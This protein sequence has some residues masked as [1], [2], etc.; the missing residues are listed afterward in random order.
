MFN[1]IKARN[2]SPSGLV[3]NLEVKP[4]EPIN[5]VYAEELKAFQG[6]REQQN[7]VKAPSQEPMMAGLFVVQTANQWMT[8]ASKL[9][10]PK[11]LFDEFWHEGEL[12]ISYSDSN[13]GKSCL[14]VQIAN[15]IT[16]GIP[17]AG[18]R[19]EADRQPV[20]LIDCELTEVQFRNRY[21]INYEGDY[22]FDDGFMQ[23]R[24]NSAAVAPEKSGQF[25]DQLIRS[26]EEL[27]KQ[28]GCKVV[29]VDNI[30]YLRGDN[31]RARD[32]LPLMRRLK[33][34]KE[35]YGLSMLLLAHTPKREGYKP[36]ELNDIQGSKMIANFC[37][38][39]FAIGKSRQG[40]SCRYLKQVKARATEIHY[41]EEN[42]IVCELKKEANF[43]GFHRIGEGPE[44]DHLQLMTP[45]SRQERNQQVLAMS[46]EGMNNVAIGKLLGLSEKAVRNIK[47]ASN[48]ANPVNDTKY[49]KAS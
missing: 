48:E 34:L 10:I 21:S 6:I 23:A 46:D 26:L 31:E 1:Q 3:A 5:A 2:Q 16:K 49:E 22:V 47:K 45:A 38:S 32:I 43:L 9:P 13:L 20:I 33:Q 17:I 18:F 15:A 8:K 4:K 41:G 30:T 40:Q 42:V 12:G 35:E 44:R 11:M 37:D 7:Q 28:T 19:L 27:I 25:E 39:A 24:I 36:I 14:A 29:I